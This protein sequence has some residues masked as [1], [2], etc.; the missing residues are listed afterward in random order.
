MAKKIIDPD[1]AQKTM[2]NIYRKFYDGEP[3]LWF[4][5]LCSRSVYIGGGETILFGGD[6]IK[7]HF[8][9]FTGTNCKVLNY[10]SYAIRLSDDTAQIYGKIKAG[11]SK[12]EDIVVT[13][14]TCI[15]QLIKGEMKLVYQH[16]PHEYLQ[17][18]NPVNSKTMTLDVHTRQFVQSLMVY[19]QH[20]DRIV[21]KCGYQTMYVDPNSI[22]YVESQR[23]KTKLVCVDREISCNMTFK[24]MLAMLPKEFYQIHRC[25]VVNTRYI[26]AIRRFEAE[27]IANIKIPVPAL[28]YMQVKEDLSKMLKIKK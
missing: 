28:T 3:E 4:S 26:T 2:E 11:T 10:E 8:S 22:L 5:Y 17:S 9:V 21:V 24:E 7:G 6:I 23:K 20:K 15:W 1:E 13:T 19:S 27:L 12:Y 14:F 16:M 18:N 25:Y